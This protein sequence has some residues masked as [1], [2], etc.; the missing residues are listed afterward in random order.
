MPTLRQCLLLVVFIGCL[1]PPH[2]TLAQKSSKAT[3]SPLCNRE[4]ALDLIKQQAALTKTFNETSRRVTV[5]VRAA[6]LLW[7]YEPD[8]ARAFFSEVFEVAIEDYKLYGRK[9]TNTLLIRLQHVDQRYVV[10]RAIA[11][12]DPAWA[13][14][15]TRQMLKSENDERPK[16]SRDSLENNLSAARLLDS[17]KQ[18][19]PTDINAALE[20]ARASLNYPASSGLTHFL[21]K[22]AEMDQQAADRFYAQALT[23]YG[24]KPMREF[25]YLQAYPFALPRTLNT[26]IFSFHTAPAKFVMNEALQRQF[27]Q[28]VLARAQ[29]AL[30]TQ[31][32]NTDVYQNAYGDRLPGTVHL[33]HTLINLEYPVSSALPDLLPALTQAREKIRVSLSVETQDLMAQRGRQTSPEPELSFQEEVELALKMP[34]VNERDDHIANAVLKNA[35]T[36]E[37]LASLVQAIE[38]LSDSNL[39]A[40]FLEWVYFQRSLAALKAKELDEAEELAGKVEGLDPRAFLH[41]ELAKALLKETETQTHGQQHLDQ[42]IHEA[43]KARKTVYAARVLLSG[44]YLYSK[45]DLNQSISLMTDAINVINRIENPLFVGD[46]QSLEKTPQRKTKGGQ[47]GGEYSLRFYMPGMDP[48]SAI[49]ELAKLDFDTAYAQSSTLGDK[50]QRALSTL[51]LAEVCLGKKL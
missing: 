22:L 33:L 39:R 14:Q 27:V 37:S 32:D 40:H 12:R 9:G 31:A 15:L 41:L 21:Y 4:N 28:A 46:D 43:K 35:T 3:R 23:T 2:S 7:P 30:E 51:S 44:S 18:L 25:L 36:K 49:R 1:V 34:D 47:Y 24:D 8:K 42:A 26:P 48:E 38:K 17:A 6:D 10:L 50:F 19:I 20:F 11:R 29:Q 16:S 45:I 13:K 5:L